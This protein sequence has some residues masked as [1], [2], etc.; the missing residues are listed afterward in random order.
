MHALPD[1]RSPLRHRRVNR[2]WLAILCG[3]LM[4][5]LVVLPVLAAPPNA[6][7]I[8]RSTTEDVL[9]DI[10]VSNPDT[11][12]YELKLASPNPVHGSVSIRP[13][14][15]TLRYTPGANQTT[16]VTFGYIFCE[17]LTVTCGTASQVTV[18]ITPVN[19]EPIA[20]NDTATTNEDTPISISVLSNDSTGPNESGSLTI[21][22]IID[23]PSNGSTSFSS[24]QVTY[25]PNLNFCGTDVFQYR[26]QDEGNLTAVAS[27]TITVS[28]VNDPPL[29]TNDTFTVVEDSSNNSL[30]VLLNDSA[31]PANENQ[32]KTIVS[33]QGVSNGTATT[34]GAVITYTP[35]ANFCGQAF[36]SYNMQDESGIQSTG[37]VTV[38][39]TCVPEV[40]TITVANPIGAG[41]HTFS[42]DL[43]LNSPDTAITALD[44]VLGFDSACVEDRDVPANGFTGVG[45]NDIT[46]VLPTSG[47]PPNFSFIP[48]GVVGQPTQIRFLIASQTNP[49]S[50]LAGQ[51][52]PSSRILATIFF[53]LK[54]NC[55][56]TGGQ[57][58][59]DFGFPA[60][61]FFGAD[62]LLVPNGVAVP[63]NDLVV[64]ANQAPTAIFLS[65]NPG[66]VPEGVAGAAAGTLSAS[67]AEGDSQTFTLV[68][69]TGSTDNSSFEI[70]GTQ[71]KL[72]PAVI[73]T[74]PR[75]YAV[76]VRSTDPFG[77][78]VEAQLSVVV[79]QVNR[80]PNAV[81]DGISP[82]IIVTHGS[83]LVI[84]VLANDTDP[85]GNPLSV[86]AVTQGAKGTVSNNT[87]SVTYAPTD[88][89]YSGPD[90]F[91]YTASD[92][93]LTDSATV[94]VIVVTND[95]RGDCN[96]DGLVSAGDLSALGLEIFDGDGSNWFD[97]YQGTF[98]GSPK[99][100]DANS[101][102]IVTAPDLTTMVCIIFTNSVCPPTAKASSS[103]TAALAVSGNL[104]AAKGETIAVPIALDT[105]NN[106]VGSA[107]FAVD[108]DAA[109]LSFDATDAD[110]DG[111]PDAVTFNVPSGL[112]AQASYNAVESRVEVVI[113][114]L[115]LPLDQLNGGTIVTVALQVNDDA[116]AGETAVALTAASLGST[117]GHNVPMTTADSSVMIEGQPDGQQAFEIFLP[118]I[119][120]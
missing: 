104:T 95:A 21:V 102:G 113:F 100:C 77:G 46:T 22:G 117:D 34:N 72:K 20:V 61:S 88:P 32:T 29:A 42:V 53:K 3:L 33:V 62:T 36:F 8:S 6:T 1:L 37:S 66:S 14:N 10:N 48:Q 63:V 75:A 83:P 119:M 64:N 109:Q 28:C 81:N 115:Q 35:T 89:N 60:A 74:F 16:Q 97:V 5:L 71:L 9:I 116:T 25:T 67:D 30:D 70:N 92:G 68:S 15:T 45:D 44:F 90:S 2:H 43:V 76:R 106:A 84:S 7:P 103:G 107:V 52:G 12:L 114:D 99:G 105:A 51:S 108:F 87:F 13:D 78:F 101:D 118:A 4:G 17:V 50:V 57:Y 38:N 65:P 47:P 26:V 41:A 58:A 24:N 79:V 11:N 85:D 112:Q 27:V 98:V 96:S 82:V 86:S 69:G 18:T 54:P 94:S 73:A 59:V 39:I 49:A 93:A 120:Q 31:G 19:D 91:S 110:A 23:S 80:A 40:P 56:L 111:I 55:P